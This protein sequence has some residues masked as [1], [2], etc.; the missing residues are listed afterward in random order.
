M[1]TAL[2]R[3]WGNDGQLLYVGISKSALSRLGQHLTE[4]PWAADIVNVTIETFPTRELAAAAEVAAIQSEK[5]LHNVTHNSKANKI[6]TSWFFNHNLTDTQGLRKGQHVALA[7]K[8]GKCYVG[9]IYLIE[10]QTEPHLELELKSW[11]TGYYGDAGFITIRVSDIA[12]YDLA[13]FDCTGYVNDDHLGEFQT[14][15]TN[16]Y[17]DPDR[18]WP[19]GRP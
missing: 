16:W 10:G 1:K 18:P 8:S 19:W 12:F 9:H 17:K 6:V 7:M 14:Y 3:I 4:K 13:G 5:P 2:Y 11:V 15:W